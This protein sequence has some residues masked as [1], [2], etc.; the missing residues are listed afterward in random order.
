MSGGCGRETCLISKEDR[1]GGDNPCRADKMMQTNQQA[2]EAQDSLEYRVVAA[3]QVL[4]L[5]T[6]APA[7]AAAVARHLGVPVDNVIP[8]LFSARAK[9]CVQSDRMD[10]PSVWWIRPVR[11][12]G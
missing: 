11:L 5:R 12:D 10:V 3:L 2:Q 8:I 4:C 6:A 1:R 7:S 9:H